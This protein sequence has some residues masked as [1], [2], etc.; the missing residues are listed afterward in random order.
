MIADVGLVGL[1][2]GRKLLLLIMLSRFLVACCCLLA[3]AFGDGRWR[4]G[5]LVVIRLIDGLI[6]LFDRSIG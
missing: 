5:W 6:D 2:T 1:A 4:S 3:A